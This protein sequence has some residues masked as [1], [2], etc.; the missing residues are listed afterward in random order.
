MPGSVQYRFDSHG[1][2]R[3]RVTEGEQILHILV[4][5]PLDL[6]VKVHV[7]GSLTQFMLLMLCQ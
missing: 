4:V 5:K 2:F 3:N 1:V 7:I 6:E